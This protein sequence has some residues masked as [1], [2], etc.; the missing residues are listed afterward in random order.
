MKAER[1]LGGKGHHYLGRESESSEREEKGMP[2]IA[3]CVYPQQSHGVHINSAEIKEKW[4]LGRKKNPEP[5]R[6]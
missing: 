4:K 6:N 3:L 2:L 1:K 5:P